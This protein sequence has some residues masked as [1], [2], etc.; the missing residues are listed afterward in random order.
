MAGACVGRRSRPPRPI[1]PPRPRIPTHRRARPPTIKARAVPR[2]RPASPP[3]GMRLS[4]VTPLA[5]TVMLAWGWRRRLIALVAGAFAA[6][7]MAPL[8]IWPALA[9]SLP[10]CVWLIDGAG[11]HGPHPRLAAF[12]SAAWSRWWF[13]FG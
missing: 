10:V 13:V 4:L 6:L 2:T 12:R 7:A 8:D 11:V 3:D 1:L 9:L 5:D